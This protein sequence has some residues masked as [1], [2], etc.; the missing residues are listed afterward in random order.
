LRPLQSPSRRGWSS[1]TCAQFLVVLVYRRT[2]W[3]LSLRTLGELVGDELATTLHDAAN[4]RR[5]D[6]ERRV[7]RSAW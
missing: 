6:S 7:A 3:L 2:S 5:T 1:W 4:V